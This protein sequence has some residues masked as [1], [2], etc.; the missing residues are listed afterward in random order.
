MISLALMQRKDNFPSTDN[1]IHI[2][3]ANILIIVTRNN[4]VW[5]YGP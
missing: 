2:F 4:I 1:T 3:Q 5:K